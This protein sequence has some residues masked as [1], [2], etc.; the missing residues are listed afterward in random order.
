M[1]VAVCWSQNVIWFCCIFFLS[2]LKQLLI[3]VS[4]LSRSRVYPSS[5]PWSVVDIPIWKCSAVQSV[6][7]RFMKPRRSLEWLRGKSSAK[8]HVLLEIHLMNQ[9]INCRGILWSFA[10][11][12]P[13][14]CSSCLCD[15]V[16]ILHLRLLPPRL[17]S[18][19]IRL[20][21]ELMA[22]PKGPGKSPN[23]MPVN[24]LA[25][26]RSLEYSFIASYPF[27]YRLSPTQHDFS[28]DFFSSFPYYRSVV[29]KTTISLSTQPSR[30]ARWK[31]R[32]LRINGCG[33]TL[34]S[35]WMNFF[36]WPFALLQMIVVK[37]VRCGRL[38]FRVSHGMSFFCV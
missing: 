13:S 24:L 19:P 8:R 7:Y 32:H 28:L 16:P 3:A 6:F 35:V 25:R 14:S 18:I 38:N 30:N 33:T 10:F 22:A 2:E 5:S 23:V 31:N 27:F 12:F 1:V 15:M 9:S 11:V 34:R 26:W 4:I 17:Q 37:S 36:P 21:W 29:Y 20:P